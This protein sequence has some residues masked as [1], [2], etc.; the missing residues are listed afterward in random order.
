MAEVIQN[1]SLK[2]LRPHNLE[3]EQYVLGACLKSKDVFARAL[4]I[5]EEND[6]YKTANKKIFQSM[7]ELFE[8]GEEIDS[9]LIADRLGKNKELDA[10]GGMDYLDFLDDQVPTVAAIAHHAKIVREKK[11]LRDLIDSATEIATQSY[12]DAEE[13][14]TLLDRAETSI[15]RI[16]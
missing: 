15:F 9:L 3:A 8:L 13:V 2:K 6:F 1:I 5:V 10:V 14:E 7:R 11:I 12:E 16:S 4:E